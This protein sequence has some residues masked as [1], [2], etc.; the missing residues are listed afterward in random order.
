MKKRVIAAILAGLMAVSTLAGCGSGKSASETN[1]QTSESG[2]E[3]GSGVITDKFKD[4]DTDGTT[5]TFWHS[6]GGILD[7][8][9]SV[10]FTAPIIY[11][12]T[13]LVFSR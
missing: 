12:L 6:M 10:I 8:F 3:E 9:D 7:R 11:A 13:L 1:G 5:I 4:I 2:K